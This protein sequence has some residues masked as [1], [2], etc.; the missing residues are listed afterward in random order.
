MKTIDLHDLIKSLKIDEIICKS[1]AEKTNMKEE[2]LRKTFNH[3]VENEINN[4]GASMY[5]AQDN[6]KDTSRLRGLS[7][8]DFMK[9]NDKIIKDK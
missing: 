7:L 2:N 5:A 1:I 9:N 3:I 4:I 8:D 6:P